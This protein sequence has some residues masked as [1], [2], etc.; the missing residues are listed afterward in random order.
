MES[1]GG[2]GT[3]DVPLATGWD[4]QSVPTLRWE[5]QSGVGSVLEFLL[6][7]QP[8]YDSSILFPTSMWESN[9]VPKAEVGVPNARWESQYVPNQNAGVP[10]GSQVQAGS[11]MSFPVMKWESHSIVGNDLVLHVQIQQID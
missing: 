2:F 5:S 3:P 9:P 4:Y 6:S 10:H 1:R 8:H 11:P 7:F